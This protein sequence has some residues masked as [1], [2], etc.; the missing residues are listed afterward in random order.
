MTMTSGVQA[1]RPLTGAARWALRALAALC[2][3]LG[4]VGVF[5]PVMPTMPFLLVAA[6]AASRSSPRL[7]QWLLSHPRFGPSLR[8]WNEAGVVPRRAKWLATIMMAMSAAAMV[9]V[10]TAA[11]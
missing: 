2:L 6:W 8:D 9:F 5:V 3:L 4:L 10:A 7:H 11:W 1:S